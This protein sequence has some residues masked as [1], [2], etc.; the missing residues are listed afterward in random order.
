MV[1]DAGIAQILEGK[2][3][4]LPDGLIR[5]QITPRDPFEQML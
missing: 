5:G 3:L 4:Q 1:V 2:P